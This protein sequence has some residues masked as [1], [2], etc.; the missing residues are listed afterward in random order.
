[1][2]FYKMRQGLC[3]AE[4]RP[5]EMPAP[6]P[7]QEKLRHSTVGRRSS[8]DNA[9]CPYLSP[10]VLDWFPA[11]LRCYH[12]T[13]KGKKELT[14]LHGS[15]FVP[16]DTVRVGVSQEEVVSDSVCLARLLEPRGV[17]PALVAFVSNRERVFYG[18]PHF[19]LD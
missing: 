15:V 7:P 10:I 1:M 5:C 19:H 13:K 6:P 16:V 18:R 3:R 2:P 14:L 17:L 11:T 12:A 8:Q 4:I 9:T